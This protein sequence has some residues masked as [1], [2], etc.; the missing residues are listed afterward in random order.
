MIFLYLVV[1]A[2]LLIPLPER[3][4]A[5]APQGFFADHMKPER[6]LPVKGF[7]VLLVF[8]RHAGSYLNLSEAARDTLFLRIDR[9]LDQL[10]V[11]MFLFYSGFGLYDSIQ[12]KGQSY[13][14][15]FPRKRLLRIWLRFVFCVC[16]FLVYA[17]VAGQH[18][19]LRQILL[20]MIGWDHIGNSNWYMFVTFCLYILLWLVFRF[21]KRKDAAVTLAVFSAAALLLIIVLAVTKPKLYWWYNTIP[22][23]VLGMWYRRFRAQTDRAVQRSGRRYWCCVLTAAL[24]CGGFL[25]DYYVTGQ[26]VLFMIGAVLFTLL[27]LLLTMKIR[28]R[29]R[30]LAFFGRHMFSI[31]MLQRL[32]FLLLSGFSLHPYV[33]FLL[34]FLL[35]VGMALAADLFFAH[36]E[37]RLFA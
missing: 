23:F 7:F 33:Y 32:S 26:T 21:A 8:F 10:I 37:Q 24:F 1:P 14:R 27:I 29:S 12:R 17:V 15:S 6:I 28:V 30:T 13:L 2:L 25:T 19:P 9:G 35:T 20:S 18:Y 11:T 34:S 36:T 31:Y 3:G 22:C 5:A 4:S 16:L